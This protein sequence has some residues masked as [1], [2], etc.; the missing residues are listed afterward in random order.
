MH[1]QAIIALTESGSTALMMS[2]SAIPIP[3]YALTQHER[4]RRRMCLC[5]GVYPIEFAPSGLDTSKPV[6]EAVD[7]MK[8]RGLLKD[9]DR[10]LVTKG[11]FTGP[12]GTN[13]MKI[14]T[15]GEA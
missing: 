15:V 2:R 7:C 1:A 6:R 3:I 9:G 12:G 4:T 10:V 5:R 11:D 13:T 8:G 14:V